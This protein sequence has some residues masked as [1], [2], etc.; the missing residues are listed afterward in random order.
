M[1]RDDLVKSKRKR[2]NQLIGFFKWILIKII[3]FYLGMEIWGGENLEI[4][5]KVWMCGGEL[6]CTPVSGLHLLFLSP[7]VYS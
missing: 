7:Q 1:N 4:S 6:V 3:F 5:F 2:Y